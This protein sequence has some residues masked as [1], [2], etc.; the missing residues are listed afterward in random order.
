M[1]NRDVYIT[2][3]K[4]SGIKYKL[5]QAVCDSCG[6]DRGYK[7]IDGSGKCHE[8]GASKTSGETHPHY[9][10]GKP[11]CKCGNKL[12]DYRAKKCI[13]CA[14][15]YE[16]NGNY[17]G[18]KSIT[19]LSKLIRTCDWYKRWVKAV[20]ERDSYTCQY[21][22]QVGGVLHVHHRDIEFSEMLKEEMLKTDSRVEVIEAMRLRHIALDGGITV[23][24]KHHIRVIHGGNGH[25]ME[26][27]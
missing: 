2:K 18:E 27:T 9:R 21:T 14:R 6:C 26:R 13:Q 20:M 10:R 16:G 25:I 19:K 23:A 22:G 24:A 8:C 1:L 5:Y 3:E 17:K 15:T 11:L 12:T 4:P 7:Q